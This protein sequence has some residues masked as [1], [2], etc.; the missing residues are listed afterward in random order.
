MSPTAKS[1]SPSIKIGLKSSMPNIAYLSLSEIKFPIIQINKTIIPGNIIRFLFAL[2][3]EVFVT[4]DGFMAFF[5]LLIEI[6]V[7]HHSHCAELSGI[8]FLQF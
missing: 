3:D 7:P 4:L 8:G 5:E 6:T 1:I 2:L